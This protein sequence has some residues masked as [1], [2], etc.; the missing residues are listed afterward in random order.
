MK[1][2]YA[3]PFGASAIGVGETDVSLPDSG[4]AGINFAVAVE[5]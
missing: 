5:N 4:G 3:M 1:L 2:Q